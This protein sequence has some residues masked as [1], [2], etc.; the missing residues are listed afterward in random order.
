MIEGKKRKITVTEASALVTVILF[1][2]EENYFEA[3]AEL[4]LPPVL[5]DRVN[6]FGKFNLVVVHFL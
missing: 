4:R 1:R 6:C 3:Q 2:D 5:H